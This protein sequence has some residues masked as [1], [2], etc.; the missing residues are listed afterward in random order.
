[1]A[2]GTT[3]KCIACG[4]FN[5]FNDFTD[6]YCQRCAVKQDPEYEK[7]QQ[8]LADKKAIYDRAEE[9]AGL[10]IVSSTDS[11]PGKTIGDYL[12]LVRGGTCRAKHAGRDIAAGLK[13]IVGG[14]IAGYTQ[15]M[16]EAREEAL[17]RMKVDA[18]RL[19]ADAVIGVNFSTAM[20]D[21]GTAEVTAFGT[22][23]KLISD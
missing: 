5:T 19:G 16:A 18:A 1:M 21:V 6:G 7:K 13:N 3:E 23:V 10:V 8:E 14:E 20:I 4:R 12:G 17:F 9:V 11:I 2:D 22:A 15:L